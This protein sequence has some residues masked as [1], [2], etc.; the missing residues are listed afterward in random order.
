MSGGCCIGAAPAALAAGHR[1]TIDHRLEQRAYGWFRGV[2]APGWDPRK[3]APY[4]D[5]AGPVGRWLQRWVEA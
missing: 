2:A 1:A 4:F 5:T 3:L